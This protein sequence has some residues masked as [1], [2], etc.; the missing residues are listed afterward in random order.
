MHIS[1]SITTNDFQDR[2]FPRIAVMLETMRGIQRDCRHTRPGACMW[3]RSGWCYRRCQHTTLEASRRDTKAALPL[4]LFDHEVPV[5]AAVDPKY[6]HVLDGLDVQQLRLRPLRFPLDQV[7]RIAV[8]QQPRRSATDHRPAACGTGLGSPRHD[9][10]NQY[11]CRPALALSPP[12]CSTPC[13][14]ANHRCGV[15]CSATAPPCAK[16][17]CPCTGAAPPMSK[18]PTT[19]AKSRSVAFLMQIT[20]YSEWSVHEYVLS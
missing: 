16:A 20:P 8:F 12:Q 3:S 18:T 14:S 9:C 19:R 10:S 11:A 4:V 1:N 15:P 17:P 13:S 6:L 7:D 5:V 2:N